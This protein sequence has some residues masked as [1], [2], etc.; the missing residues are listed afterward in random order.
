MSKDKL[1][2]VRIDEADSDKL[3]SL[4]SLY[5]CT[6]SE[7]IRKL[8]DEKYTVKKDVETVEWLEK[9]SVIKSVE[10]CSTITEA[11]KVISEMETEITGKWRRRPQGYGKCTK[12]GEIVAD[13]WSKKFCSVC[14]SRNIYYER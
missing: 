4:C 5:G 9:S 6:T 12:C 11:V 2:Q 1:L 7:I 13:A 3:N 8:I 14:G 10:G